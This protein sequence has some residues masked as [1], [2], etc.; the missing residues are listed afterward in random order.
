MKIRY[1][2]LTV[3][4]MMA[5]DLWAQGSFNPESPAE[6]GAP[7]TMLVLLADPAQGGTLSGG[8]K[9]APETMVSVRAK[10]STGFRF[11]NWTDTQGH[12]VAG[13]AEHKMRKG[14]S[15]DT[16]VAHF[17]YEP[18]SPSEPVPGEEIAY[19]RLTVAAGKGGSASGGGRYQSGTEI[20]LSA[21]CDTNFEF[22]GWLNGENEIVSYEQLFDYTTKACAETLTA[23]FRY[24]PGNPSEPSDPVLRH[25]VTVSCTD[26]GTASSNTSVVYEGAT[27]YLSASAN[28]GYVFTGWYLGGELYTTLPSFSYTMGSAD[29]HFEARFEF[30]PASPA[31]PGKPEDKQFAFYLMSEITYPGTQIDCPLYL[32][33]LDL[34]RDMTFQ[35]TFPAEATPDWTTL[36]LNGKAEGYDISWTATGETGV[37]ALTLTGGKVPAGNIRLLSLKLNVPET[38]PIAQSYQVRINQVSV[39]K[40]NGSTVTA[41]TR[42]GR[43]YVYD[44]GDTNGDGTVNVTDGVNMVNYIQNGDP[45]DGSFI[46]EVSDV[47]KDGN[48]NVTDIVGIMGIVQKEK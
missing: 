28:N 48:H 27:A 20:R 22:A 17:E 6:P 33:S 7:P 46:E 41:S 34:L 43:V 35:L 39:M 12:V 2:S 31:E 18:A 21:S 45:G 37:Y 29:A 9:Y 40:D 24:N 15:A 8:G 42:N 25:S 13:T 14:N 26:G 19:Y 44:L 4:W 3:L 38:V 30:N 5:T 47:S 32:T 10:A 1:L 36:E 16:L 23:T 11:V